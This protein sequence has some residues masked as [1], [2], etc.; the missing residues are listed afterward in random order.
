M[1]S[2]SASS[3]VTLRAVEE[4]D[5]EIFFEHQLDEEACES[6][7]FMNPRPADASAYRL[8]WK[9]LLADPSVKTRTI[10]FHRPKGLTPGLVVGHIASFCFDGQREVSYWLGRDHWGHGIGTAAVGL[11]LGQIQDRPLQARVLANNPASIRVLQKNGFQEVSRS[12]RF[13]LNGVLQSEEI[14]FQ[15]A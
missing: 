11:A 8:H 3:S 7:G 6:A 14:V 4:D 12:K 5:I 10:V 13:A 2:S 1:L 9:N 15:F